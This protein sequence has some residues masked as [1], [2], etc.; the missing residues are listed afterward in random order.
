MPLTILAPWHRIELAGREIVEKEQRLGA[1]HDD[2]VDAH[3]DEIDADR[4]E[5]A[6]LD[7][8]LDLGADAVVGGD[9]HRDRGSPPP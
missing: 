8:D 9:Q 7:R 4:V 1:L 3:R 5:N 2:V 6:A